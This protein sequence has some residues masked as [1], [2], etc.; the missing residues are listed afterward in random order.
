M[1]WTTAKT[2]RHRDERSAARRLVGRQEGEDVAEHAVFHLAQAVAAHAMF[3]DAAASSAPFRSP[4][5]HHHCRGK[6]KD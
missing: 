5:C 3:R 4:H 6:V 2:L 1:V